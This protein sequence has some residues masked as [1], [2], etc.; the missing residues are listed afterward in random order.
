MAVALRVG[1]LRAAFPV[2]FLCPVHFRPW[3]PG[4][5]HMLFAHASLPV[6]DA[7]LGVSWLR[8]VHCVLAAESS[9]LGC[10]CLMTVEQVAVLLGFPAISVPG[11]GL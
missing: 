7:C 6:R 9:S 10:F 3:S 1:D 8:T 2:S 4:V 5:V 11:F